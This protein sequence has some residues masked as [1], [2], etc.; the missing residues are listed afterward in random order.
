MPAFHECIDH[1]KRTATLIDLLISSRFLVGSR[2]FRYVF[3]HR[4]IEE[5]GSRRDLRIALTY[6]TT[7]RTSSITNDVGPVRVELKISSI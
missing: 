5:N 1:Q 2:H 6:S 7:T 4:V 3:R